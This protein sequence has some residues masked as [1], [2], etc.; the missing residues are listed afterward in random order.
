MAGII[1]AVLAVP[2]VAV[3]WSIIKVWTGR[4]EPL[5]VDPVDRAEEQIQAVGAARER[6]LEQR[7][8]EQQAAKAAKKEDK[9]SLAEEPVSDD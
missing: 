7:K 1:G 6:E 8:Q 3:A 5:H 4:D 9:V 2:L